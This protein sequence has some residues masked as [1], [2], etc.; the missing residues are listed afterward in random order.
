MDG[1]TQ[2]FQNQI[3]KLLHSKCLV[4]LCM[5]QISKGKVRLLL[6]KSGKL[7]RLLYPGVE[8]VSTFKVA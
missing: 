1:R 3:S 6:S 7:A 8:M 2:A 4:R 5:P